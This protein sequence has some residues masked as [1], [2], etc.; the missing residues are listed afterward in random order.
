MIGKKVIVRSRESGTWFG[1]LIKADGDLVT[2][3]DA[4]MMLKYTARQYS[5]MIHLLS[6]VSIYGIE[7][8]ESEILPAVKAIFMK[9]NEIYELT[10]ES[11]LSIEE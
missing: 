11:I 8:D 1:T 9:A 10:E 3:E 6:E 4:R 5:N 7:Q 2:L